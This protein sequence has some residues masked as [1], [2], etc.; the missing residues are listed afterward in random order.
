[1]AGGCVVCAVCHQVSSVVCHA[2]CLVPL[3][4]GF[5]RVLLNWDVADRQHEQYPI[6]AEQQ[7]SAIK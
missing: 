6:R 3:S 2:H 5:A 7:M 1:M 4:H